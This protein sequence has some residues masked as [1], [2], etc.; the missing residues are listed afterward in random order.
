M[1]VLFKYYKE[2]VIHVQRCSPGTPK[3]MNHC[4]QCCHGF[5][6]QKPCPL[7]QK[8]E[9]LTSAPGNDLRW[10]GITSCHVPW[11]MLPQLLQKI[12]SELA[13][14]KVIWKGNI[15]RIVQIVF[16]MPEDI[17]KRNLL[18]DREISDFL[19]SQLLLTQFSLTRLIISIISQNLS[20]WA[21]T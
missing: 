3:T 20:A 14:T 9:F 18:K 15:E 16:L 2:S 6:N 17:T 19:S 4:R 11:A 10:Y 8:P 21:I 12:N 7:P 13:K 1:K 5:F